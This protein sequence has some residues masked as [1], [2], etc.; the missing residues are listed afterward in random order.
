MPGLG[1]F[2]WSSWLLRSCRTPPDHS[3]ILQPL[4]LVTLQNLMVKLQSHHFLTHRTWWNKAS[5]LLIAVLVLEGVRH[6]PEECSSVI[7]IWEPYLARHGLWCSSRPDIMCYFLIELRLGLMKDCAIVWVIDWGITKEM[8]CVF[9]KLQHISSKYKTSIP[10]ML[11][12]FLYFLERYSY[13]SL[14]TTPVLFLYKGDS[15]F[16]FVGCGSLFHFVLGITL[17]GK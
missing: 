3:Q 9:H 8:A 7:P 13:F 15:L 17:K 12:T 16:C 2:F 6:A 10:Q 4:L 11:L 5:F 1:C 14:V